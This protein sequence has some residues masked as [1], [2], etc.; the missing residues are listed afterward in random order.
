MHPL[1][2][3][4]INTVVF[5]D[6]QGS[7]MCQKTKEFNNVVDIVLQNTVKREESSTV[8]NAEEIMLSSI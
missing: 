5:T 3:Y 6:T 8:L 1:V 2:C 7:I 4:C